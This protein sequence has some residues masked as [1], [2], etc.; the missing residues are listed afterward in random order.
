MSVEQI[1][2]YAVL[3]LLPSLGF[4]C[5]LI[6]LMIGIWFATLALCAVVEKVKSKNVIKGAR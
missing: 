5:V 3:G 1:N 6:L 2:M 4:V